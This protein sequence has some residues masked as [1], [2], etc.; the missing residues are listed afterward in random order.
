MC[1][2][3]WDRP[4]CCHRRCRSDRCRKQHRGTVHVLQ[5]RCCCLLERQT[6]LGQQRLQE[7][8]QRRRR[9]CRLLRRRHSALSGPVPSSPVGLHAHCVTAMHLRPPHSDTQCGWSNF[10]PWFCLVSMAASI[11]LHGDAHQ[12]TTRAVRRHESSG[13]GIE[14]WLIAHGA[15]ED[16]LLFGVEF[17]AAASH[18]SLA[19]AQPGGEWLQM[20]RSRE[21]RTISVLETLLPFL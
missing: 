21:M 16:C 15:V 10:S 4:C 2:R 12:I 17:E 14:P 20:R 6:C 19:A 8:Q 1:C 3:C 9:G 18:A 11:S 5:A 7:Q 13:F